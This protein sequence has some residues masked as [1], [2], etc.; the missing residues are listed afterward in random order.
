[1]NC[2][3]H[4]IFLPVPKRNER[5]VG[6]KYPWGPN[7]FGDQ[8]YGDQRGS[9]YLWGPNVRGDQ[10]SLGTKCLWGPNV[11][12]GQISAGTKCV[13]AICLWGPIVSGPN[14]TQWTGP[15]S[16]KLHQYWSKYTATKPCRH[17]RT[18]KPPN[19]RGSKYEGPKGSGA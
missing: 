8:M 6:A 16:V 9:N 12:G 2:A 4:R 19:P 10:I 5:L 15:N 1:M 11:H 7:A 18:L 13:G 17:Y 3:A 14:T